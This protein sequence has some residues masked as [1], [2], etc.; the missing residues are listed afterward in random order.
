MAVPQQTPRNVSTAS[1]G[2]TVF[3]YSFKVLSKSDLQVQVDGDAREVDVHY[4]IDG[5]GQDTGGNITFIVPMIGGERVMRRRNMAIKRDTD[6]QNLGDLRSPTLNNDQDEP[7]MMMQ[8][9]GEALERTLTL[10]AST[11][12]TGELP[13]AEPLRPLVWSADGT[14]LE[15][16]DT[17]LT[18]DLLLRPELANP[19]SGASLVAFRNVGAGAVARDLLAR[20]RETIS[21]MDYKLASETSF[22]PALARAYAACPVGG[23]ITLPQGGNFT[24]TAPLVIS[25]AI[26][27]KGEGRDLPAIICDGTFSPFQISASTNGVI[28]DGL[29]IVALGAPKIAGT[30]GI[31]AVST[32]LA[33]GIGYLEVRNCNING[34]DVGLWAEFCQI[35]QVSNTRLWACRT[36]YYSRRSVNM[37]LC[38]VI[39]ESNTLWGCN[40]TGDVGE[41]S[42]SAGTLL[43]LCEIFGNGG[44]GGGTDG[45]NFRIQFN[46]HFSLDNC[47]IDV[48]SVGSRHN[49]RAIGVSR[50]NIGGGSWIGASKGS[51]IYFTG[52]DSITIGACNILSSASY[53][54]ELETSSNCVINGPVLE[55]NG[56]EDIIIYG[57]DNSGTNNII[58]AARL[59][60]TASGTSISESGIHLTTVSNSVRCAGSVAL[61]GSSFL[62]K[63]M[64]AAAVTLTLTGGAAVET[65]NIP[66]P[67]GFFA[68]KPD[69]VNVTGVNFVIT[70]SYK[71]PDAA[72]TATNA[73]GQL[74]TVDGGNLPAGSFTMMV[75][76]YG[77]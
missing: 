8:Q 72:T 55:S 46:E 30:A 60:S 75:F 27:I 62:A 69:Y 63:R 10:P 68:V 11:T 6:Y 28:F 15:N 49:I 65:V 50:G 25:K 32:S 42:E 71:H 19:E 23:V 52:C 74:V 16:G 22:T 47:M 13:E 76:A 4:T 20:S 57:A 53:G 40:I 36:G 45:G 66:L 59:K 24:V 64:Y 61:N 35:G 5:V 37:A 54:I 7:I 33:A 29:Q 31:K 14:R 18:G 9:L 3:P 56:A 39:C 34:F 21:V 41:I 38:Q 67:A 58:S 48:P 77:R 73:R 17:T 43:S 1:A 51:G 12:A 26:T 2:A 70:W 44:S